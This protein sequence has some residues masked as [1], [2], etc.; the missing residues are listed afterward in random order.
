MRKCYIFTDPPWYPRYLVGGFPP[1]CPGK[2]MSQIET[3]GARD[4][5][6]TQEHI[7]EYREPQAETRARN[8]E[9]ETKNQKP[10]E[11]PPKPG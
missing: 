4:Y 2:K 1:G 7:K 3:K 11:E 8:Q 10:E 9:S 5:L 6:L